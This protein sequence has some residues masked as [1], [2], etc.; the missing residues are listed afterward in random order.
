MIGF[1]DVGKRFKQ[2]GPSW[3]GACP[4]GAVIS[5]ISA[6]TYEERNGAAGMYGNSFFVSFK[7]NA[8]TSMDERW[9]PRLEQFYEEFCCEKHF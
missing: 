9:T 3:W 8:G 4:R 5:I 1:P 6:E 7:D 2:I